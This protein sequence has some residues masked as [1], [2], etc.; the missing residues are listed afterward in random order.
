M[1]EKNSYEI[2]KANELEKEGWLVI[3]EFEL[4]R[5]DVIA[6]KKRVDGGWDVKVR[7]FKGAH[8]KISNEQARLITHLR[9]KGVDSDFVF[10]R[11]EPLV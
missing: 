11:D 1:G 10:E 3:R 7:E 2:I 8:T 9:N 6:L 4:G 5:P